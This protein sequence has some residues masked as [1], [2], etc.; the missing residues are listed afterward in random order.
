MA[1]GPLSP[2]GVLTGHLAGK[3]HWATPLRQLQVP[4]PLRPVW[5]CGSGPGAGCRVEV[6]EL[7]TEVL[8]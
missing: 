6:L 7:L 4:V 3:G 8:L 1:P 5:E 2:F